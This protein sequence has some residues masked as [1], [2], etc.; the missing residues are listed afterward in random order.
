MQEEINIK[1]IDTLSGFKFE[2]FL[3]DFLE[4]MEFTKIEVTKKSGDFGADL[5]AEY[6]SQKWV[7]Q[8]KRWNKTIGL[9]SVQEVYSAKQYYSAENCMVISNREYSEATIKL[10]K[11]CNCWLIGRKDL[12]EWLRKRFDSTEK[13]MEH[14]S[15]KEY[16][17]FRISTEEM[18]LDYN[19]VKEKIGKQPTLEDIN[20]H[21]K[22]TSSVYR[23]RFGN[24]TTFL[25]SVGDKPIQERDISGK[26]L[27]DNYYQ[28]KEKLNRV[29]TTDDMEN[30]GIY[31][32]STY[33]R[34]FNSCN[35]FLKLQNP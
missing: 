31:S 3:K 33:C 27:I 4:D 1:V 26:E 19:K 9:K 28:V 29:P 12:I 16:K 22:Y 10:A 14:I 5:I 20:T 6:K 23:R 35:N 2:E 7:I 15:N 13:F 18:I 32:I 24:W 34:R 17:K 21:G 8:A 11:L 30:I 25:N